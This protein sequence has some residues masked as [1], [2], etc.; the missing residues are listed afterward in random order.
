MQNYD[1]QNT[2]PATQP[3]EFKLSLDNTPEDIPQLE[4]KLMSIP[5]LM[6]EKNN[7]TTKE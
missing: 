5:E 4:Q 7:Q 3:E 1:T 6:P 2:L